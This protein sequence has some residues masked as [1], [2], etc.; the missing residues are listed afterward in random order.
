MPILGLPLNTILL[1]LARRRR[2]LQTRLNAVNYKNVDPGAST[3]M[4]TNY[5]LQRQRSVLIRDF[6]PLLS[7]AIFLLLAKILC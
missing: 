1:I 5:N 6:S 7:A 4:Q 3:K 2:S